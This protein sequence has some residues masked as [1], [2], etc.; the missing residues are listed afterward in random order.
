MKFLFITKEYP[1]IPDPS[2]QI[3]RTLAEQLKKQGHYVDVIARDKSFHITDQKN[4]SVFWLKI[5]AW[6]RLYKRVNEAACP[7]IIKFVYKL[8]T[9]MRKIILAINIH[10]FPN[11]EKKLTRNTVKLYQK[12]LSKND[13]DIVIGFFRP[14][15][16]LEAAVEIAKKTSRAKCVACYFDLVEDKSCPSF[17]PLALYKKLIDRGDRYIFECC[18]NV[19]LPKAAKRK[20]N[21]L[22][23]EYSKK[24]I[25]YEFPTFICN[26]TEEI[27]TE[28]I[29]NKETIKFIFAGTLSKAKRNPL[30]LLNL[31]NNVAKRNNQTIFQLDIFGGGDC[32]ELINDYQRVGNFVINIHG[33]VSKEKVKKYEQGSDFLINIMNQYSTLVPS[34]IFELFSTGKPIINVMTNS[35]DGSMEYF[36]KYPA[37]CT[38]TLG[39]SKD[40]AMAENFIYT[41]LNYKA[42]LEMI[43][44]QYITCTPEYVTKQI[45]SLTLGE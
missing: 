14:Y 8:A 31:L 35:D 41:H 18:D 20:P 17:M 44:T 1:P 3:V 25:F 11:V 9:W 39:E 29:E 4:G 28:T 26:D 27:A 10:N 13:Y 19:M 45:L 33:K 5:N 34:K 36:D 37:A 22:H 16:C 32:F 15:S 42:D 24:I 7:K 2:G 38:C 40:I 21:M 12:S 30:R 6:E 43:K 23:D